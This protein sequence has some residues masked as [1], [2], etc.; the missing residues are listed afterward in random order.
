MAH[1]HGL[2]D[3]LIAPQNN[4]HYYNAVKPLEVPSGT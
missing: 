4:I 3:A 2:S 1:Y